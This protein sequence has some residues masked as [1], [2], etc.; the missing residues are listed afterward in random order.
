MTSHGRTLNR[1]LLF[2]LAALVLCV[3]VVAAWPLVTGRSLPLLDDVSEVVA[4]RGITA[5]TIA[6]IV[7]G[8]L[9]V[10]VVVALAV[11]LTR[12]PRRFRAALD[13]DGVTIDHDVVEDLFASALAATPDVLGVSSA[14]S[15][16]RGRRTVGLT[17][18]LR[19]RAD[20]AAVLTAVEAALESTDRLLGVRL[21]LAVQLTGGIRSTF[22][23]DRRVV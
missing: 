19:P 11:I 18:R 16:R 12:P 13:Q 20:L 8:A 23:H 21:P 2:L 4:A 10:A 7:A 5:Q 17:V 6:W 1:V 22:A 9:A 15:K 3:G 14:T